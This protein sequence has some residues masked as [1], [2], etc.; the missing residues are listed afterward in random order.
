[1][2]IRRLSI[3]VLM[4]GA[5]ACGLLTMPALADSQARIVRLSDVEG[6]VQID[7]NTGQGYEKAFLNMPITEGSKLWAKDDGRAEVEFEDGSVVRITP[8]TKIEFSQ[9]SLRDSGSKN[10]N[11]KVEE[12]T[13]YVNFTGQKNNELSL[14]FARET[15]SL[16]HA[17]HFRVDLEDTDATLAV[18]KGD[19]EVQG[20]SGSVEVGK[21][22]TATFDLANEDRYTVAKNF[23][24]DPDDNWN[25]QQD[26]YHERY[27]NANSYSGSMPYSYGVSDLNYYGNYYNVP[28]YGRCWRPYFTGVG[29]DPFSNGAWVWYPGFGY[30]WVS[31]YPWGWMPYRYGNWA[32][33]PGFGWVWQPGGWNT[34]AAI[35]PVVNP[36]TRFTPPHPPTTGGRQTIAVGRGPFG[37]PGM[38]GRRRLVIDQGS[39]GMGVPRGSIRNMGKVSQQVGTSGSTTVRTAP[40]AR[41][42]MMAPS[43]RSMGSFGGAG[44]RSTASAPP[45][46]APAAH[47]SA[48]HSSSSPHR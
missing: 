37:S 27:L 45:A 8:D 11:V 47:A 4:L 24:T 17:A 14:S 40:P 3:A 22:Q 44:S 34:W 30:T 36:P 20:P 15:V 46:S 23:E 33:A 9:L 31:S 35:P 13:A 39:G 28:G 18:L 29:W 41:V 26:Q 2:S 19:V 21:K 43:A 32:F 6:T 12:G 7:R 48:P 10:T 25:K 16:T 1:M 5:L 38:P 42:T